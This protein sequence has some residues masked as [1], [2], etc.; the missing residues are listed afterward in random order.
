ML[1]DLMGIVYL[2]PYAGLFL[3]LVLGSIGL[4]VPEEATLLLGGYLIA[5]GKVSPSA[6]ILFLYS[7]L[8]ASDFIIYSFGRKFARR[9]MCHPIMVRVLP[10]ESRI[11]IE[12]KFRKHGLLLILFGRHIIGFRTKLFLVAG[13]MGLPPKQFLAIDAVAAFIS[14]SVVVTLGYTGSS[15]V[16]V[17]AQN[18][19]L[20]RE[21]L[22][23]TAGIVLIAMIGAGMLIRSAWIKSS[24]ARAIASKADC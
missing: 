12:E 16:D 7:G 2:S 22:L 13:T 8:L 3:L 17:A 23:P 9:L 10:E 14:M 15:I 19:G 24:S 4:P 5:E 18:T 1:N 11:K 20:S 6:A 21:Q